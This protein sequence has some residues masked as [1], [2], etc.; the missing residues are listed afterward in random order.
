MEK[1]RLQ[2]PCMA[3]SHGSG[4][5]CLS[6]SVRCRKQ[7]KYFANHSS[8]NLCLHPYV[9]GTNHVRFLKHLSSGLREYLVGATKALV[10]KGTCFRRKEKSTETHA[11]PFPV[12]EAA[13]AGA[14]PAWS[15]SLPRFTVR[16]T[17][18]G[19]RDTQDFYR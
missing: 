10:S 13:G 17:R 18:G 1:V 15:Q 8:Q 7:F 16:P 5:C 2:S 19:T 6:N 9:G 11:S 14:D 4:P 12:A 3:R